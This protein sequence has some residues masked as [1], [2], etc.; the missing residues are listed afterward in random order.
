MCAVDIIELKSALEEEDSVCTLPY[1][2]MKAYSF[3]SSKDKC[4]TVI[5]VCQ[6]FNPV[7]AFSAIRWITPNATFPLF[8]E[9]V[10]SATR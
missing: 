7:E 2:L 4:Y 5:M 3:G 10:I 6:L 9:A 1:L 8:V